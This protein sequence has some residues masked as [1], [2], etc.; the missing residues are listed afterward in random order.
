MGISSKTCR[1]SCPFLIHWSCNQ[2]TPTL[3]RMVARPSTIAGQ[4]ASKDFQEQ[5]RLYVVKSM[6]SIY[7]NRKHKAISERPPEIWS[8]RLR[9]LH[10]DCLHLCVILKG[11]WSQLSAQSRFFEATKRHLVMKGIV[12]VNP[13]SPVASDTSANL[14]NQ[15]CNTIN[16]PCFDC[17]RHS[18][19][20]IDVRGVDSCGQ[21]Y[22]WSIKSDHGKKIVWETA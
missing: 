22:Y 10:T 19:G 7:I 4:C 14:W 6:C 5:K 2:L 11:V 21:A 18:N 9:K 3:G 12:V 16:S 20:S 15:F 17:I 13:D 1:F 8:L